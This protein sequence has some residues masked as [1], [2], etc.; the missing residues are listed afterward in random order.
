MT[1]MSMVVD[2]SELSER[3]DRELVAIGRI[4]KTHGRHGEVA[5]DVLTDFP[6]RFVELRA[7]YLVDPSRT[8][9]AEAFDVVHSRMHKGRPILKLEGIESIGAA[10]GLSGRL[11]S[12]PADEVK[13][14]PGG[15]FYHFEIIGCSVVDAELGRIGVVRSVLVTGGTD[16]LIVEGTNGDEHLIPFCTDICRHIDPSGGRVEVDLPEGLWTINAD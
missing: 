9:A 14:L 10:E 11:V 7:V 2:K 12:I 13:E 5:V 1:S 4:A 16:V 6:E 15:T 3:S 8:G